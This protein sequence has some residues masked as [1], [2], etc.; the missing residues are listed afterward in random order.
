MTSQALA[1]L[2]LEPL[3]EE[4]ANGAFLKQLAQKTGID[5]RRL[6]EQLRKHPDY[7]AAKQAAIESQIDDAQLALELARET[8]DIARA[9]EM[10]R[11][12]AWRAEHEFPDRWGGKQLISGPTVVVLSQHVAPQDA[13]PGSVVVES[14]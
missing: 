10:F 3:I 2:A 8:A 9:R 6:S 5:K 1:P 12:A 14:K 11:A 13:I 7:Q 4:I